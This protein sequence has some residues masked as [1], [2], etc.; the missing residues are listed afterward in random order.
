R[1]TNP[2]L[3]AQANA[4]APS[5]TNLNNG[6]KPAFGTQFGARKTF[7]APSDAEQSDDSKRSKRKNP[8]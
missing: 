6:N 7:G 4:F 1:S 2:T 3:N 5:T 8:E